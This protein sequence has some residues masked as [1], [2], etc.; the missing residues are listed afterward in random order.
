KKIIIAESTFGT[1][2]VTQNCFNATGYT[3]LAQKYNIELLNLNKS[4][5]IEVKVR[6]PLVLKSIKIAKE[7]F[8]VDRIINLPVMKVHYA[9]GVT[10]ALKNLKGLLAGREKRHFHEV[11]LARAIA[12]LNSV[13]KPALNIVDGISCME[14]MG[15]R[16]GDIVNLN[17]IIAGEHAV[18]VDYVAATIMGFAI[19][20]VKHLQYYIGHN[21]IDIGAIELFGERIADVKYNFKKVVME[22]IVPRQFA[23]HETNACCAC[24]NAFLLSCQFLEK[25]PS[26]KTHIY[27]GAKIPEPGAARGSRVAFGN[28]CLKAFCTGI[29]IP[30]CPPYPFAL[31]AA[32]EKKT[33]KKKKSLIAH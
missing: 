2:R 29:A 25:K 19:R 24:M 7:V 13:I 26:R 12:D 1:A 21:D 22:N 9:T 30:G 4:A 16:G 20:E 15:P 17:L 6:D 14:R 31:K 18:E 33:V 8:Q 10:L 32:L 28:C 3:A 5:F 27:M 23:V 11:G